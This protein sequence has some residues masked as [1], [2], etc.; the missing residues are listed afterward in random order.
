MS[1]SDSRRDIL[2]AS[3]VPRFVRGRTAE[4]CSADCSAV[5]AGCTPCI[6]PKQL[7]FHQSAASRMLKVKVQSLS[8]FCFVHGIWPSKTPVPLRKRR[9]MGQRAVG[10]PPGKWLG[11]NATTTNSSTEWPRWKSSTVFVGS[12]GWTHGWTSTRESSP[13]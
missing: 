13:R 1:R 3:S 9:K 4:D 7:S 6:Q 12:D 2:L 11:S 10:W 8:P 5:L